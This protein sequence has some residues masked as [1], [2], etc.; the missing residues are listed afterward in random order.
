MFYQYALLSVD[1]T[2]IQNINHKIQQKHLGL[3]LSFKF[4]LFL[5]KLQ[6]KTLS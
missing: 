2:N 6:M 5:L 4:L 3:S 1:F